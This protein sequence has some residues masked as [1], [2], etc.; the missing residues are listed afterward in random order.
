M[1]KSAV[2]VDLVLSGRRRTD[3]ED[4]YLVAEISAGIRAHDVER[5]A[6]RAALLQKLGRDVIPIV[7]GRQINADAAEMASERGV[8]HVLEGRAIAPRP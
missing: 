1:A 5:A 6:D 2:L 3:N 8:W 7:A 4:I